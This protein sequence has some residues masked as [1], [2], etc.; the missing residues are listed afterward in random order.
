ML[1][2]LIRNLAF[3]VVVPGLGG[4]LVPG[5]L[6]TRG[7]GPAGHGAVPVAWEAVPV[8]V[9]GAAL[10]LWCAWNFAA[11]GHGTP[12]PW[13]APRRVVAHGPYRWVRN[14]IYLAALLVVL[15]EAGLF[16]SLRLLAY[17]GVLAVC[18]HL[19]VT[20]YEESALRRRFGPAYLAYRHTV[21][22]WLPRRPHPVGR[23]GASGSAPYAGGGT[24]G[25]GKS[26][27]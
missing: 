26:R 20:G 5:W 1:S 9:A 10:Y 23:A 21:P 13:D 6:L 12:G 4:A 19:F 8:I 15:G 24:T 3:T 22:R 25:A 2:L 16:G 17:A 14:P 18:F 27:V 11:V 7:G